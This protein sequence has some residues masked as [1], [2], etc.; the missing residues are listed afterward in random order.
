MEIATKHDL[1]ANRLAALGH[2]ARLK[3]YRRLVRRG[4]RGLTVGDIQTHLAM[5]ASTLA[6]HLGA[7][8]ACGLVGQERQ[9]REV[10]CRADFAVMRHVIGYLSDECCAEVVAGAPEAAA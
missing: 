8:V 2:P 7:L 3:L 10:I 6:H 9:G 1:T 5:P 4:H